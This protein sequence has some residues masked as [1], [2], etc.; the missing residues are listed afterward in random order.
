[1]RL[2]NWFRVVWWVLL[3]IAATSF[4]AHRY[5]AM[6]GGVTTT[7][8]AIATVFW[9]ALVLA[10]V[11][12]E[13]SFLGV[14]L[15]QRIDAVKDELRKDVLDLRADVQSAVSV[16]S[17]LSQQVIIPSAPPDRDLPDLKA[18]VE[19]A[20]KSTLRS[21]GISRSFAA[22]DLS[23]DADTRLLF[24]ARYSIEKELRRLWTDRVSSETGRRH[25]P[26]F[27]LTDELLKAELIPVSL[28]GV[29]REIYATCSPALH[30]ESATPAQVAFVRD[31]APNLVK[32]LRELK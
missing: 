21:H 22:D 2:P 23:V 19:E 7:I 13:L 27:R 32:T 24:E 6:S 5:D 25:L 16:T 4:L 18:Q 30:G 10:P 8:D 11:F 26:V 1:M 15:K 3:L 12:Y 28:V 29:I 20:I 14:S 9:I 17:N 31:V